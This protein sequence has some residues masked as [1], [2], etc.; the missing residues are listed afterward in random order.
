MAVS[1]L[2]DIITFGVVDRTTETEEVTLTDSFGGNPVTFLVEGLTTQRREQIREKC[3]RV[4]DNANP[5]K[6][7]LLGMNEERLVGEMVLAGIKEPSLNNR[8][9]KEKYGMKTEP[10]WE[11]PYRMFTDADLS[12]L[13]EAINRVSEPEPESGPDGKTPDK[14]KEKIKN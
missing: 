2:Q 12:A 10:L 3:K 5:T 9:L 7:G 4:Y 11:L 14:I 6:A 1:T 8:Q 13:L